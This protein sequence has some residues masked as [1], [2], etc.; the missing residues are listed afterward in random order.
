MYDNLTVMLKKTIL[1]DLHEKSARMGESGGW[2]V[3]LEFHGQGDA[4]SILSGGVGIFDLSHYSRLRLRGYSVP[5]MFDAVGVAGLASMDDNTVREI[6]IADTRCT[7]VRLED[8]WVVVAP[9]DANELLLEKFRSA[10]GVKA[11]SQTMKVAMFALA[12]TT[13]RQTLAGVMPVKLP[14]LA[15]GQAISGSLMLANYI[16]YR[17]DVAGVPVINVMLPAIFAS[18]AWNF[19]TMNAG[20]N[21]AMPLGIDVWNRLA[22]KNFFKMTSVCWRA[23]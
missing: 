1:G 6:N 15:N 16:A 5:D 4:E 10:D 9:P 3:P 12:G 19:I 22:F 2:A 23:F 14:S 20:R 17:N 21:C 7:L 8:F 11:D 13:A 18:K